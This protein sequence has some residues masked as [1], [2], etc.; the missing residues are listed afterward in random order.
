MLTTGRR[1][2]SFLG[3]SLLLMGSLAG[4]AGGMPS[5]LLSSSK[6]PT[7]SNPPNPPAPTQP[8]P[9]PTQAG[10]VTISPQN[11]AAAPG[12]TVH[13]TAVVTGGGALTW[14]VNGVAGGN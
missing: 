14:S 10:T 6:P 1:A 8:A 9:T 11:A 13:F 5:S 7:P 12:Q 3:I 4:C 2:T